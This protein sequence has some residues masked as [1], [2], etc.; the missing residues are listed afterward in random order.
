MINLYQRK[1]AYTTDSGRFIP[2]S[3]PFLQKYFPK[4]LMKTDKNEK[5]YI[6]NISEI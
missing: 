3:V 1:S 6:I 5:N 4:K 2:E